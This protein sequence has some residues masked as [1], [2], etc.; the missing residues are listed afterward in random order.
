MKQKIE[1]LDKDKASDNDIIVQ[2]RNETDALKMQ[3]GANS[4]LAY[5]E[6][7]SRLNLALSENT[8]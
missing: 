5:D 6:L 7:K 4:R 8:Q 2:L 1:Q 3:G